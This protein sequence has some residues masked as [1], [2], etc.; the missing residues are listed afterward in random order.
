MTQGQDVGPWYD[1]ILHTSSRM[2]F[3]LHYKKGEVAHNSKY[4]NINAL[5]MWFTYCIYLQPISLIVE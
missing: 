5:V 3:V 2:I 1:D 4:T